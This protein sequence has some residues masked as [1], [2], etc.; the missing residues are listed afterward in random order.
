MEAVLSSSPRRDEVTLRRDPGATAE[1]PPAA[2]RP[3][4][5]P[6]GFGSRV[7]LNAAEGAV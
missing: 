2:R 3:P 7:H 6:G 5:L 1:G 4:R